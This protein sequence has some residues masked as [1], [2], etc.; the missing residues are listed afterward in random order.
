MYS[1]QS[2]QQCLTLKDSIAQRQQVQNFKL[3][4]CINSNNTLVNPCKFS[5]VYTFNNW[6]EDTEVSESQ[7]GPVT[8]IS[9][10]PGSKG[11]RDT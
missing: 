7:K 6:V 2:N 1:G 4:K 3:F 11:Y 9:S 5:K 8:A 10:P